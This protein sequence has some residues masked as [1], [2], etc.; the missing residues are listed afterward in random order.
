MNQEHKQ[1]KYKVM[2]KYFEVSASTLT[3]VKRKKEPC[4]FNVCTKQEL[5]EK[6]I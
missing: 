3:G 1:S 4:S 6:I 2:A 5:Y